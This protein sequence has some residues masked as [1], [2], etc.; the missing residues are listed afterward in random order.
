[1]R[2]SAFARRQSGGTAARLASPTMNDLGS[3]VI[4]PSVSGKAA[5][6]TGAS[7]DSISDRIHPEDLLPHS[8]LA[9]V[10]RA[11]LLML[12]MDDDDEGDASLEMTDLLTGAPSPGDSAHNR[13]E[14][15]W[16][17]F[18]RNIGIAHDRLWV[19]VRTMSGCI[20][21]TLTRSLPWLTS[22]L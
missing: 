16:M 5:E 9:M 14:A 4:A 8:I 6:I 2:P 1:M 18:R 10:N 11:L 19:F 3:V 22:K 15:L 21:G 7:F 13:R 20:G 17:Q 12:S